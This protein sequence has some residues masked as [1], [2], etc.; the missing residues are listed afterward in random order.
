[1]PGLVRARSLPCKGPR[2]GPAIRALVLVVLVGL[3]GPVSR[4]R[5]APVSAAVPAVSDTTGRSRSPLTTPPR[6]GPF[7]PEAV[8]TDAFGHVFALDRGAGRI[9]RFDPD[10]AVTAFG[11]ADQGADRTPILSGIFA[12]HGPDLFAIDDVAGVLY[13]F[14]LGGRLRATVPYGE[15]LR[16][17]GIV[18]GRIADFAL[19]PSGE[20]YLLDRLDGRLLLF[21]RDGRFVTDLFAGLA[22]PARPRVPARLVVTDEGAILVL[23]TAGCRVRRLSREGVVQA[24]WPGLDAGDTAAEPP[25]LLAV[26][27]DG[28]VVLASRGEG[29]IWVRDRAGRLLGEDL[30]TPPPRAP[31]SDLEV[32]GD[33][34]LLLASPGGGEILRRRLD[35]A[36]HAETA[37]PR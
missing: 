30:L 15:G 29:R 18:P 1:M 27:S 33:T 12:R 17:A 4:L 28:R 35:A 34:L 32:A 37:P 5:A 14:D 10:G 21:D 19:G 6:L 24:D 36:D 20:L 7:V 31:L 8:A 3:A 25:G 11:T 16:E 26:A 9:V 13:R 23:D 22:G 2:R